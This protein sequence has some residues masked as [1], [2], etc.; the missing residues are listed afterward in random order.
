MS[1][2]AGGMNWG[3]IGSGINSAADKGLKAYEIYEKSKLEKKKIKEQK[4]KTLA[5]LLNEVMGRE[6]KAGEGIRE[7]GADLAKARANAMQNIAS[8]YVQALR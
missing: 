3:A 7:R 6:F 2:D 1:A 4:R 5:E 8:Q